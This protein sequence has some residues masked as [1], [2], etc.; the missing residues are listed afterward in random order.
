M[1][2]L[3]SSKGNQ[4]I[5][6]EKKMDAKFSVKNRNQVINPKVNNKPQDTS[7]P[8]VNNTPQDNSKPHV[9]NTPQDNNNTP[10]TTYLNKQSTSSIV[11]YSDINATSIEERDPCYTIYARC[12]DP[13][14]YD[15]F[16][17]KL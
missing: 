14:A 8:Q 16:K 12:K 7:K 15:L 11:N 17:A 6:P 2:G 9:N 10:K 5:H 4:R 1:F 3:F 13:S